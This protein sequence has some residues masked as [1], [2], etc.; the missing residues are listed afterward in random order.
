MYVKLFK[1]DLLLRLGVPAL[2]WIVV[3]HLE[4]VKCD[5]DLINFAL[6]QLRLLALFVSVVL[7]LPLLDVGKVLEHLVAEIAVEGEAERR[8]NQYEILEEVQILHL[9][10]VLQVV[11]LQAQ[12]AGSV[13]RSVSQEVGGLHAL[14]IAANDDFVVPTNDL[15]VKLD[16]LDLE[17]YLSMHVVLL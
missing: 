11:E 1:V 16:V 4:L 3:G 15:I 8:D 6:V 13:D 12:E 5:L 2:R 14:V 7:S 17:A 10:V 9:V